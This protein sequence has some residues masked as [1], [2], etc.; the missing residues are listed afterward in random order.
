MTTILDQHFLNSTQI[1]NTIENTI[2]TIFH[3]DI[4][5]IGGGEGILT[6]KIIEKQP[7]SFTCVEI[8]EE[9]FQAL[10]PVFMNTKYILI[11][12]N[13]ITYLQGLK[14]NQYSFIVAN[15]PYSLTQ[16]IYT[17][18]LYIL[19]LKC[20]FLQPH[21]FTK[22]IL[23]NESKQAQFINSQYHFECIETVSGDKFKPHAKTTSSIIKLHL[24]DETSKNKKELLLTY[25]SK[26]YNQQLNN[27]IIFSLA[28]LLQKGKKEVISI[29][30]NNNIQIPKTRVSVISNEEFNY[31]INSIISLFL[32]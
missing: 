7:F 9:L 17:Q 2:G 28:Q 5:E 27:A 25:I 8:D 12:E 10:Q 3:E 16:A 29:I 13:A 31:Y 14:Q 19:P 6:K 23:E 15:L 26:R 11:N 4:L 18:I 21:S 20:V 24:K 30:E 22:Q 32:E 1:L